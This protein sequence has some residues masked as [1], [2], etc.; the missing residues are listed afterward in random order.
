MHETKPLE[1]GSRCIN[2]SNRNGE[3]NGEYIKCQKSL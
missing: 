2:W 1:K 3:G